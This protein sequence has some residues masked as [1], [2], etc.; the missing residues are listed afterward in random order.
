M[1]NVIKTLV[2]LVNS[3][4]YSCGV[5]LL[6]L[7]FTYKNITVERSEIIGIVFM[8]SPFWILPVVSKYLNDEFGF[9]PTTLR[10]IVDFFRLKKKETVND[11]GNTNTKECSSD[12]E[13]VCNERR[14]FAVHEAGHAV[15]AYLLDLPEYHVTISDDYAFTTTENKDL[16][17]EGTKKEILV[18]YS[19]A[20]AEELLLGKFCCGSMGSNNA[21]FETATRLIKAYIVMTNPNVSKTLLDVELAEE[22]I[23]LS[24]MFYHESKDIL[25]ENQFMLSILSDELMKKSSMSKKEIVKILSTVGQKK[26][27]ARQSTLM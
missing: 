26:E 11:N 7:L 5:V 10:K 23:E 3:I 4:V 2:S 15:M 21:D 8:F 12:L 17:P 24:K 1:R 19:A 16:T 13:Q 6:L 9:L 18:N 25:S 14:T 27:I 20:V 22:M